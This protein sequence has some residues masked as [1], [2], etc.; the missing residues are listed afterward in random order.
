MKLAKPITY[1]VDN[2]VQYHIHTPAIVLP[3][4]S[5]HVPVQVMPPVALSPWAASAAQVTVVEPE[6]VE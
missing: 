2:L 3:C 5:T 4:Y 1:A 6:A